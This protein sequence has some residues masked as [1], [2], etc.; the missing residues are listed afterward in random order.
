MHVCKLILVHYRECILLCKA[1]TTVHTQAQVI[2]TGSKDSACKHVTNNQSYSA[3]HPQV[4]CL[5]DLVSIRLV[6]ETSKCNTKVV[7]G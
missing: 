6:R 1:D 7:G 3:C 4:R 5:V 2:H